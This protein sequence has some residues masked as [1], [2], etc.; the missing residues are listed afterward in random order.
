VTNHWAQRES[1]GFPP[2][3]PTNSRLP[4]FA[5]IRSRL[6]P[7]AIRIASSSSVPPRATTAFRQIS[8]RRDRHNLA[9]ISIR[10]SP[11]TGFQLPGIGHVPPS[12]RSRRRVLSCGRRLVGSLVVSFSSVSRHR[13]GRGG[14]TPP[15]AP[16]IELT[17]RHSTTP[18]PLSL[19]ASANAIGPIPRKRGL[20]P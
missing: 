18:G 4:S 5:D 11:I 14:S 8:C 1:G 9:R 19:L 12:V 13:F 20:A 10:R 6:A 16:L 3:A 17:P 2:S 15:P 7:T